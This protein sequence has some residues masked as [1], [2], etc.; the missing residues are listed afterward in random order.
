[1]KK[2]FVALLGTLCITGVFAQTK[3]QE[4][5]P[6]TNT[7]PQMAA[8]AKKN[9]KAMGATQVKDGSTADGQ[10]SGIKKTTRSEMKGQERQAARDVKPHRNAEQGGTPK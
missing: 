8:E 4:A 6:P 3:S 2:Q 7:K 5:V 1:M 9:S 10:G